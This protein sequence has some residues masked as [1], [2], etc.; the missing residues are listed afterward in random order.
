MIKIIRL[1]SWTIITIALVACSGNLQ[2]TIPENSL[3]TARLVGFSTNIRIF[4]D[5]SADELVSH[6]KNRQQQISARLQKNSS[7]N[8][9]EFNYL[10]LSGG[11][12][13]G[14]FGAGLLY[15]WSKTGKRP[16]FELV[17]GIST[18][19]IIAPYA[20]LGSRYDE[21]LKHLFTTFSADRIF[22]I[23]RPLRVFFSGLSIVDTE[24]FRLSLKRN[25]TKE[26]FNEIAL[27]HRKGR[28]LLIGTTHLDAERPMI[29]DIGELANSG[30]PNG[31]DIFRDIILASAAVPGLFPPV[32]FKVRANNKIYKEL[33]VDG[34]VT[35]QVFIYPAKLD[36]SK[37]G[38][39][40]DRP[41]KRNLYIIRNTKITPQYEA[42]S[43][44]I[45]SIAK[46]SITTLIKSQGIGDLFK[47]H[48]IAK[49]DN[50]N[51]N[52]AYI[53]PGF[54]LKTKE[55]F[56]KEYM[57]ALFDYAY[58]LARNSYPWQHMPPN[59]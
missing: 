37:L 59:K 48:A 49:R 53:P 26:M 5:A 30:N 10:A 29:W 32:A 42:I 11:A 52:L 35:S 3:N 13:D 19:A 17:S 54:T 24:P 56:D 50:M 7:N 55:V 43:P 2:R 44:G 41:V 25:I 31:L 58:K 57:K 12:E 15:G 33:H 6:I 27:E 28:R 21:Q 47:L 4:G 20:F 18:G 23:R 8:P 39:G 38:F 46:R 1:F 45:F 36:L 22:R 51:Y 16:K 40:Y 14:A 34:G 9:V